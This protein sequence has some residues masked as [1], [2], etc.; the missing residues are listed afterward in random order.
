M[1]KDDCGS[2]FSTFQ[3]AKSSSN[4][5]EIVYGGRP[6][7]EEPH[8]KRSVKKKEEKIEYIVRVDLD[9]LKIDDDDFDDLQSL[10]QGHS[11]SGT[12]LLK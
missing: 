8:V 6:R 9:E 1:S 12:L 5:N 3:L 11:S 7:N 10:Y 4:L 2:C